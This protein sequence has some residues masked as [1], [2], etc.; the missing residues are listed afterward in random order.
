M[1]AGPKVTAFAATK[2]D[3]LAPAGGLAAWAAA[4]EAG[5]DAVYAGFKNFSARSLADNFS[6]PEFAGLIRESRA[7][8]VKVHVAFNSLIKEGE[9]AAAFKALMALAEMGPDAFI[10]QDYGLAALAKKYCP[11]IPLHASTLTAVYS[12]AGL[13]ALKNLGFQRAV[14]PREL[15][16]KEIEG[17]IEGDVMPLEI[18]VHGAMCFSFSGLCLF[19]SYLGGRSASR[20]GCAQPCRR[21]YQNHGLRRTFFSAADLTAVETIMALKTWPLA[22]FKIEGRM[23]GPEYV[24]RTVKAYRLLLD[25]KEADL[26]ET[27]IK[28]KELLTEAGGR[29]AGPGFL[30][31]GR[32]A[33]LAQS[34]SGRK[35][36]DLLPLSG[37]SGTLTLERELRLRDRLRLVPAPGQEGL[38]FKLQ[39][40]RLLGGEE[41]AFAPAGASVEIEGPKPETNAAPVPFQGTLYLTSQGGLEKEYLAKNSVKKVLKVAKT[42]APTICRLP[43]ELAAKDHGRDNFPF[44]KSLWFWLSDLTA[45]EALLKTEPRRLVLEI[46]A[47]N[48]K[49]FSRFKKTFSRAGLKVVFSFPALLF[50]SGWEKTRKLA[51]SLIDQGFLDFMVANLGQVEFLKGLNPNLKIWGDHRLGSLNHLSAKALS[52]VGLTGVT[53]S[54]ELDEATYRL[55]AKRPYLSPV[56]LYLSGRPALFTAR[57]LPLAFKRG[58][59]VSLRGEKYQVGAEGDAFTLRAES[60]IFMGGYLKGAVPKSLA[61]LLVDL[62]LEPQAATLARTIRK[63]V[64]EGRGGLGSSFNFK[65][66]LH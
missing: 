49:S 28:V 30:L 16:A 48:V 18:F 20:G 44:A 24:S 35:V 34:A 32:P 45:V 22:A 39:K 19:S 11:K 53:L 27:L 59:I 1:L 36:G 13:T 66:G 6:L 47:N 46:T 31:G 29:A 5:A 8:G 21:A 42:Y 41:V 43:K 17:L 23:K 55:L 12:R 58:P 50:G 54:P 15:S 38:A 57:Y 7:A 37:Y 61:G 25:A 4:V 9:L 62:R 60:R 26:S 52:Q 64:A 10:V 33:L 63:A 51:K 2:P 14:L 3:L 56:L 65:R 40:M